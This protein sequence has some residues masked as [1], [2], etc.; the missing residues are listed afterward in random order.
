MAKAEVTIKM[1]PADFQTIQDALEE[2][3]FNGR[4]AAREASGQEKLD[5]IR[6]ASRAE[7]LREELQNGG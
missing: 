3:A 5:A 7:S 4:V 2:R 1:S 6:R